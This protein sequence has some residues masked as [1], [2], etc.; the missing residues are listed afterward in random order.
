[1]TLAAAVLGLVALALRPVGFAA[2][3][4]TAAAGGIGAL[5]PVRNAAEGVR[6]RWALTTAVGLAGFAIVAAFMPRHAGP[7]ARA[8]A[9]AATLLAAVAEEA[10]FRRFLYGWLANWGDAIALLGSALCFALV[11]VPVY[12]VRVLPVDVAA[13]LV[14]SWQRYASG[15][16][17]SPALTHA[18]ANLVAL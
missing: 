18:V 3:P 4:L 8:P 12:G 2:L 15:S 9:V 13:G 14:L 11:H 5:A 6:T 10:F 7:G 1:V 17:T 16:W